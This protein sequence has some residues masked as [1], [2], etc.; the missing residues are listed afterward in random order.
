MEAFTAE[1]LGWIVEQNAASYFETQD[2]SY[3]TRIA[4]MLPLYMASIR[5]D[6]NRVH[7]NT[8]CLIVKM[9]VDKDLHRNMGSLPL[10]VIVEC[11]G[12]LGALGQH[13][14][15]LSEDN[16]VVVSHK[17]KDSIARNT[18]RLISL[19]VRNAFLSI[20]RREGFDSGDLADLKS[21]FE[22]CKTFYTQDDLRRLNNYLL[23]LQE[24]SD[25]PQKLQHVAKLHSQSI[26][27]KLEGE[28]SLN[29]KLME[30][31]DFLRQRVSKLS[32]ANPKQ[33]LEN[34]RQIDAF[35]LP[36]TIAATMS[37]PK[38]ESSQ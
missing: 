38:L 18:P 34:G 9:Y 10:K 27:G 28:S 16:G 15:R 32:A 35:C 4:P 30:Y 7:L 3:R 14:V 17:L 19:V 29:H 33:M 8:C 25:R 37:E 31:C 24:Y 22:A 12:R 20:M 6:M 26:E 2:S 11:L 13:Y 21:Q 5:G 23:N 36:L 1:P